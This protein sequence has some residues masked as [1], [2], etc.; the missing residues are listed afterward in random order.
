MNQNEA[1]CQRHQFGHQAPQS[2]E[3]GK[4]HQQESV[5]SVVAS[6][7]E[8]NQAQGKRLLGFFRTCQDGPEKD[9]K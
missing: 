3:L 5:P 1:S 7:A 4:W 8:V 2:K 9:P 6:I